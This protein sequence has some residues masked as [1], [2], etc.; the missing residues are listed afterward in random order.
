MIVKDTKSAFSYIKMIELHDWN[1]YTATGPFKLRIFQQVPHH[2]GYFYRDI[3]NQT[4]RI[5]PMSTQGTSNRNIT[6]YPGSKLRFGPPDSF[7]KPF[8]G[9]NTEPRIGFQVND[10]HNI[11]Q[12]HRKLFQNNNCNK[13][14]AVIQTSKFVKANPTFFEEKAKFV[15]LSELENAIRAS[16]FNGSKYTLVDIEHAFNLFVSK[17]YPQQVADALHPEWL[18][19]LEKINNKQNFAK[20]TELF[21]DDV[22]IIIT[23]AR[24]IFPVPDQHLE[25][26]YQAFI[27]LKKH[28]KS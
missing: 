25:N 20:H 26:L 14:V 27:N 21:I 16:V 7:S 3:E 9:Y 15:K 11:F 12:Q 13:H 28:F 2:A 24:N 19:Y 5:F 17:K 10:P 4:L 8:P 6:A 23:R 1:V 18:E 22:L